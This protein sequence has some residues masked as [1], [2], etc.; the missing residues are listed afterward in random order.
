MLRLRQEDQSSFSPDAASP[1]KEA[2]IAS[3]L[4]CAITSSLTTNESRGFIRAWQ[5]VASLRNASGDNLADLLPPGQTISSLKDTVSIVATP[6][7]GWILSCLAEVV[8]K[9]SDLDSSDSTLINFDKCR[10]VWNLIDSAMRFRPFDPTTMELA[11]VRLKTLQHQL[12]RFV[13]DQR[14]MR[15]DAAQEAS[16][17]PL[18]SSNRS[19]SYRPLTLHLGAQQD[20]KRNDR[21]AFDLIESELRPSHHNN[22]R[23]ALEGTGQ[24]SQ[25]SSS[26]STASKLLSSNASSSQPAAP[27]VPPTQ[28]E[29]KTRRM[30]ALFRGAVRPMGLMTEKVEKEK[31]EVPSRSYGELLALTPLHKPGLVAGCAG[32]HVA[33]WGNSQR[34]YVFH[35]T[36]QEG[37]KYL[38]Q[39]PSQGEMVEWCSHIEKMAK[40]LTVTSK[41]NDG[42]KSSSNQKGKVVVQPLYG[43]DLQVLVE[44]EGRDIPV[45]LERML[46]EVEARGES[47]FYLLIFR[48]SRFA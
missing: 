30:T 41:K 31:V 3:F 8:S 4:E 42:K 14:A 46:A 7:V 13:W 44:R 35:L 10:S 45:G 34:S 5:G 29:K 48:R 17:S 27:L 11:N 21:M 15:E 12:S 25:G 37:H 26:R 38:L 18:P 16:S 39:A 6:D 40:E 19:R 1:F 47:L 43:V 28:A 22:A 36:S 9:P 33:V 23:A 2:T 20:K 24:P 32:A